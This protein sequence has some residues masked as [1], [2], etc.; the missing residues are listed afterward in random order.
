[1]DEG[2]AEKERTFHDAGTQ[3]AGFLY[4]VG[5]GFEDTAVAPSCF[6]GSD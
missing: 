6:D 3:R 5:R 2:K 4:G 1:M